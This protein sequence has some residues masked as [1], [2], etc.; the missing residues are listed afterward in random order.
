VNYRSWDDEEFRRALQC[1]PDNLELVYEASDRFLK[2]S[3][4]TDE[5]LE[6]VRREGYDEGYSEGYDEGYSEGYDEGYSEGQR[7]DDSR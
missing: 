4:P 6:D 1:D 7:T 2:G 5:E 3:E